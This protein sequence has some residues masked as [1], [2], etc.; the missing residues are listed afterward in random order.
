MVIRIGDRPAG[1]LYDNLMLRFANPLD[2]AAPASARL[3]LA[4]AL[5][6]VLWSGVFW[7]LAA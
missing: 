3:A 2:L 6:A 1:M 4:A 5:L 7:A